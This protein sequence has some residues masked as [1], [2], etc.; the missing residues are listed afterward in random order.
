MS[1]KP[2]IPKNDMKFLQWLNVFLTYLYANLGRLNVPAGVLT[3]LERM[4]DDFALKLAAAEDPSTRTKLTV[5]AKNDARRATEAA[6][7]NAVN[8][9]LTYNHE[10]TNEDRDGLGI[11][12]RKTTRTPAPVADESPDADVDTSVIGHVGIAF[13]EKGKK[14]KK[15]KPEGQHGVEIGWMVSDTPPAR[16]D[17]L[18]HSSID[19]RSPFTLA[20][21]N[22]ERGKTVYFALRWENTRGEKGPWSEIQ[23]AIIP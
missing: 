4:R 21:E 7:R 13:Y 12:T 5:Q 16:W 18:R 14:H 1:G 2:Y 22:D 19:T 15:A 6:T 23:S 20:F 8:E 17:E 9:Y 3:I 10:V 11:P